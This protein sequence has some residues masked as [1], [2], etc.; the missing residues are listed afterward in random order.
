KSVLKFIKPAIHGGM[1]LPGPKIGFN[2]GEY[3]CY[4]YTAAYG[5]Q[6]KKEYPVGTGT[7]VFE[8]E[9][10]D[11]LGIYRVYITHVP[12]GVFCWLYE[13]NSNCFVR[14]SGYYAYATNDDLVYCRELGI[15]YEVQ[16]GVIWE[17]TEPVFRK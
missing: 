12:D 11:I 8:E 2:E 3:Q 9:P 4:D 13:E 15:H 6:M 16:K 1:V 7:T 14:G 5:Y 17:K 10:P